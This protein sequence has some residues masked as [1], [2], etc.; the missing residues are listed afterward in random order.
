MI[1]FHH[2]ETMVERAGLE[3]AATE[4]FSLAL[5]HWSYLSRKLVRLGA[6]SPRGR[7]HNQNSDQLVFLLAV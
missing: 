5:Y 7:R 4:D 3:P 2:P 1:P 6:S